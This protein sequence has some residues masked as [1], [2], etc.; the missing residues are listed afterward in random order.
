MTTQRQVRLHGGLVCRGGFGILAVHLRQVPELDHAVFGDGGHG[1]DLGHE[2]DAS[3]DVHVRLQVVLLSELALTVFAA[4]HSLISSC[5]VGVLLVTQQCGPVPK[6]K[7]K[8]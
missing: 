7:V 8:L 4:A 3:D 6:A 5:P 2:L 1:V